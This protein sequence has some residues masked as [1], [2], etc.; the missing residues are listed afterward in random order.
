[1][2]HG[3]YKAIVFNRVG[4]IFAHAF[5]V[6][7]AVAHGNGMAGEFQHLDVVLAITDRIDMV[8]VNAKMI[9]DNFHP[10]HFCDHLFIDLTTSGRRP[11]G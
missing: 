3:R 10:A 2:L 1:M 8:F 7:I 11:I 9:H 4:D 6:I 5:N